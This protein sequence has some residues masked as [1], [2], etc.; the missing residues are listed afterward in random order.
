[1]CKKKRKLEVFRLYV[2]LYV[3]LFRIFGIS[4]VYQYSNWRFS[5]CLSVC[6]FV[7]LFRIFEILMPFDT[8]QRPRMKNTTR[9]PTSNSIFRFFAHQY[10]NWRFSVCMYVC[11][12]RYFAFLGFRRYIN[13]LIGGFLFV[14]LFVTLFRIFEISIPFDTIQR[15]RMKNTTRH[16]TSN[17]IFRF[18]FL[19]INTLIG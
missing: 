12:S 14:C 5:V 18:F 4:T 15:P 17:T 9:H 1:M 2:C 7:T 10:S 19:H 13:T 6:L 16:P 11:M 8:I 3:T